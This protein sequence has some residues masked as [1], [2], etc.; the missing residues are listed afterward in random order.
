MGGR[1]LAAGT[2]VRT[3]SGDVRIEDL[4]NCNEIVTLRDGAET[5]EPIKWVGRRRVDVKR[6]PRPELIAPV[7]IRAGAIA[8]GRPARDVLVSPEHAIYCDGV[9]VQARALMNGGSIF[10]ERATESVIYFHVELESHGVFF[11]ENLPVESYL[12]NGDRSFFESD[13]E[14][15]MLHPALKSEPEVDIRKTGAAYAPFITAPEAVEPIWRRIAERSAEIGYSVPELQVTRNADLHILADG[16][17]IRP[18]SDRDERYT[19]VLPAGVQAASLVSRFS[20][21]VD[22]VPY[23]DDPRRLGVAVKSISIKTQDQEIVVPVDFP[24]DA[25]G[26][27][28]PER[29]GTSMWRWTDGAAELPLDPIQGSAVVTVVCRTVDGYPVYDERAQPARKVA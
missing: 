26:W 5:V 29:S 14:A 20:I 8:E 3:P 24:A 23:A 19:F 16:K 25:A 13:E 9:L 27:Y 17:I 10:Q 7:R 21:P 6:H 28:D 1:C 11:A 2:F 4:W 12:D 18:I 15:V 22:L